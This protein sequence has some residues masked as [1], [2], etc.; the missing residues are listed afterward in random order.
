VQRAVESLEGMLIE[1]APDGHCAQSG[2]ENAATDQEL[3]A[4]AKDGR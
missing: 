2:N 1:P 4:W 3:V